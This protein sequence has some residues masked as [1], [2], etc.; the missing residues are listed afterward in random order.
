[1]LYKYWL[2][3][4]LFI[5]KVYKRRWKDMNLAVSSLGFACFLIIALFLEVTLEIIFGYPGFTN[6]ISQGLPLAPIGMLLVFVLLL[7]FAGYL[8]KKQKLKSGIKRKA[9]LQMAGIS[10]YYTIFFLV[11]CCCLFVLTMILIIVKNDIL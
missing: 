9:I 4:Y 2:F 6:L 5:R 7:P 8:A 11:L 10:K 1:M 3:Y